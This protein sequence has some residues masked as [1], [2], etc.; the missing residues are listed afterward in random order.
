MD[1]DT[2]NKP[3]PKLNYATTFNELILGLQCL[4]DVS[5]DIHTGE[6]AVVVSRTPRFVSTPTF[7][8]SLDDL[9]SLSESIRRAQERAQLLDDPLNGATEHQLNCTCGW[10]NLIVVKPPGS[11]ARFTLSI[12]HFNREGPLAE[13]SSKEIDES[14]VKLEAILGSVLKKVRK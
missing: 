6:A 11:P 2:H 7:R 13:L 14:I 9:K 1:S 4:V 3:A 10:A 8:I 5:V 12:G